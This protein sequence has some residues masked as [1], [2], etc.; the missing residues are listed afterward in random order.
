MDLTKQGTLEF[1]QY[2]LDVPLL[3]GA[4]PLEDPKAGGDALPSEELEMDCTSASPG[5]G[6]GTLLDAGSP[7]CTMTSALL[8]FLTGNWTGEPGTSWNNALACTGEVLP[9][10]R[11]F[12][13]TCGSDTGVVAALSLGD[14]LGVLCTGKED[15]LHCSTTFTTAAIAGVVFLPE[16]KDLDIALAAE[17]TST[18]LP[19][20]LLASLASCP[21]KVMRAA[22]SMVLL[23]LGVFS[24]RSTTSFWWIAQKSSKDFPKS[25]LSTEVLLPSKIFSYSDTDKVLE[26]LAMAYHTKSKELEPVKPLEYA[27]WLTQMQTYQSQPPTEEVDIWNKKSDSTLISCVGL[28]NFK[29]VFW[30]KNP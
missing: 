4:R 13:T 6:S 29:L 1:T 5:S 9:N 3:P 27:W 12:G 15:L 10:K 28:C 11:F 14:R 8:S 25:V 19:A 16:A 20:K 24:K 21:S 7:N 26:A 18:T 2:V 17:T 22:C 23:I 30:E